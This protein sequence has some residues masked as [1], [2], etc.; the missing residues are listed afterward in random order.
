M[1]N[2][3]FTKEDKEKIIEFLNLV[4]KHA[5]FEMNTQEIITYFKALSFMQQTML[6]KIEANILEVVRVVEGE[7]AEEA[8]DT[9]ESG[10]SEE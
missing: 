1:D 10:V 9:E 8:S 2:N 4:A 7:D 6:P 3:K 5:K